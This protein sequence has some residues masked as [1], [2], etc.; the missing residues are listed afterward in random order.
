[1]TTRW[2]CLVVTALC[3][4]LACATSASAECAWVLWGNDI[5]EASKIE[6]IKW[7]ADPGLRRCVGL[8]DGS[9]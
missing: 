2:P 7:G 6:T 3:C 9:A 4:L 5:V 1:M 8:S